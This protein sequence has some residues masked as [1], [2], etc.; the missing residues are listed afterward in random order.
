MKRALLFIGL[1]LL[2]ITVFAACGNNNQGAAA[3][4]A[5]AA[6]A[7]PA[8][9]QQQT[10]ASAEDERVITFPLE[11]TLRFSMAALHWDGN[12]TFSETAIMQ[13]LL[14]YAN[15]EIDWIFWPTAA[16]GE[17]LNLAFSTGDYP[18][19]L[20]G[21][22]IV[23]TGNTMT[24]AAEG[25]LV[26]IEQY[27]TPGI[28]PNLTRI[29][30]LRPNFRYDKTSPDGHIYTLTSM[31]EFS[32]RA[33]N[34]VHIINQTW[35]D[36]LGLDI[37]TTTDEL[38]DVLRAFR[39]NA[40]IL[41]PNGVIPMSIFWDNHIRGQHSMQG[42]WGQAGS[43]TRLSTRGDTVVWNPVTEEYREMI[44]F[45]NLLNSE[46]LLDPELFTHTQAM[47][48]AKTLD[49][50]NPSV[51]VFAQWNLG[52]NFY[53]S[54]YDF[55][56]LPPLSAGPGITPMWAP[57]T[58]SLI[59]NIGFVLTDASNE[60]DRPYIMAFMDLFYDAMTSIHN[61]QGPL[62]INLRHVD[63]RYFEFIHGNMLPEDE[64][65]D[66]V[67]MNRGLWMVL[68]EDFA[69]AT[70]S[71]EQILDN[72][73]QDSIRPYLDP[74]PFPV[75]WF[76]ADESSEVSLINAD[77]NPFSQM[78]AARW[79]SGEGDIDAE[80]DAYVAQLNAMGL[81]RLLEINQAAFDRSPFSAANP[82]RYR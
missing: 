36:R 3:D 16:H 75:L 67:L 34:E 38:L 66:Y 79:V 8:P 28:M 11:E 74:N 22:W 42:W 4:T 1:L 26:P 62:D 30:D 33:M 77:I 40:D 44:R 64:R 76:T 59:S 81:N 73:A 61:N 46:G 5:P 18:D 20:F 78:N 55:S 47:Y 39:D 50:E 70:I 65:M 32:L 17:R 24:F 63:G 6:A 58:H 7:T 27:I 19:A 49:M 60:A 37:P 15:V 23:G 54:E 80:W 51:G 43:Q 52:V 68:D 35:L 14:A 25:M 10:E 12:P 9:A 56:L 71:H 48:D 72:A 53:E 21:A 41:N 82:W 69:W 29:L 13:E 57:R 2:A 31:T 45:F